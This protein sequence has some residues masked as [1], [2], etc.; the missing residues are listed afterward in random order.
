MKIIDDL[1]EG[2][3]WYQIS[4]SKIFSGPNRINFKMSRFKRIFTQLKLFAIMTLKKI[5]VWELSL[6]TLKKIGAR[7]T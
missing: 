4:M 2:W 5:I 6:Q 7:F 3:N 1:I